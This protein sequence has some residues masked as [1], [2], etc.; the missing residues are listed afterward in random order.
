MRKTHLLRVPFWFGKLAF[1]VFYNI[2]DLNCRL[3]LPVKKFKLIFSLCIFNGLWMIFMTFIFHFFQLRRSCWTLFL[4]ILFIKFH[5]WLNAG[6][7]TMFQLQWRKVL[8]ALVRARV[9]CLWAS[10]VIRNVAIIIFTSTSTTK[11]I[12]LK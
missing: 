5:H 10:P 8:L 6:V 1:T 7:I 12:L 3:N 4:S 11:M 2:H 9:Y